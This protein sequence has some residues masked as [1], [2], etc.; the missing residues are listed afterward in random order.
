LT[1]AELGAKRVCPN[2]GTKYYDLNRSPIV[3]PRCGAV[4]ETTV[5]AKARPQPAAPKPAEPAEEEV[6]ADAPEV[7]SLGEADEEAA[8]SG[9]VKVKVAAD[10]DAD[11]D[12]EEAEIDSSEDE[13]FLAEEDEDDEDVEG[14]IGEVDDEDR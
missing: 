11:D 1:K 5:A 13:T 2:C 4:F 7:I 6:V 12:E 8:E 14:I 10:V 3:C 9:Q